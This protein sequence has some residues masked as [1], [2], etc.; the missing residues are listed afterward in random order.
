MSP[1]RTTPSAPDDG[2]DAQPTPIVERPDG[3]YWMAGEGGV[4][5][6]PFD[7]YDLAEADRDAAG[8]DSPEPG[9]SLVEAE[10]EIGINEWLDG[11]TGA[12]AEGQSPPRLAED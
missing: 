11:E 3:Y 6:G 4:E 10:D 9:E 7:S 12:P 5:V 1:F 2:E 8:A